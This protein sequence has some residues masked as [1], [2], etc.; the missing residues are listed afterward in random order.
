VTITVSEVREKL[1]GR[2][3]WLWHYLHAD[4]QWEQSRHWHEDRYA[5]AVQEALDLMQREPE[6]RYYFDTASEFFSAVAQRLGPRLEELKE[7]V[8]NGRIRLVSGQVANCR[9]TQVGDETYIRNLQLGREYFEKNLPPTDLSLFHSVDVA[10]GHVQMPQLLNLAGFKYYK[11]W[12]P[13][14][15]MNALGI[16]HQFIWQGID[17]SR[18]L[19]AR[20]TYGYGWRAN[21]PPGCYREDWEAAVVWLY[22]HLFHDQLLYDRSPT[23]HLWMIQGYDDARPLTD[24]VGDVPMDLLGFVAE[25]RRREKI[26]IRWCTPLEYCQAVAG[27]ADRLSVVEGVLD[28]ADCAYNMANSGSNGLWA[29][30]QMN[31]R[32]LLRAEW[33]AAAAASAGFV[34]PQEELK[35]LW[36]QHCIYQAHAQDFAFEED[37]QYLVDLAR[38]VKFHAE[39]IEQEAIHRIVHA[40]GGGDRATRYIFNPHPWP[41]EVEVE[42]YHPCAGAGVESLQVV[43]ED[44]NP[45]AQQQLAE[46]R[47]P[48]FGGSLNDERRLVRLKLPPMGYR[49]VQIVEK[50]DPA[51]PRPAPPSDGVVETEGLRLVYRNHAL[52]EVHDRATGHVYSSREGSPWPGLFFH[53]LDNQDWIFTGPEI[54][55]DRFVPESSV[56]LQ[57]GPLRWHHRSQGTLGPYRVQLDTSV[58]ERGRELQVQVCL[59]GHWELG[60]FASQKAKAPVTG[61]VTL[62]G[63]IEAG[64]RVTVDVPFAVEPRDPD[65]DIYVHN[66][67]RDRDLGNVDMFERLRPGVF[68]G[69]SWA[70]WSGDGHGVTLISVDG[71]YYWFKEPGQFGHILLRCIELKASTWE[72]FCPVFMT[73]TGTHYFHYAFRF[74]DGDWRLADPQRRSLEL[75]HPPVVARADYFAQAT[76]PSSWHSFLRLDGPALLS[77]YYTEGDNAYVRLYENMG[78]GGE[79]TLTLDWSPSSAQAVNLLGQ[80]LTVPVQASDRK[81]HV[82]LKPWQIVTLK[83]GR[84]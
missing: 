47:H 82:T 68:W 27:Q 9:P 29:W 70:D 28:G 61:F 32:R 83:L 19:V 72:A 64:G 36:Y 51:P 5:L 49:R 26:P 80:L 16:P 44:G 12:R 69:R 46:F 59:D 30:R 38:D 40:A 84:S 45:L 81:V 21:S 41:V 31:D 1:A 37:W 62:L 48:R 18:I 20:G 75:R 15:P 74:H 10:I 34:S 63:D 23:D 13:H 7:H 2:T 52:R 57:A 54:R 33:W 77:A 24:W 76:L 50:S 17:G 8:H 67:P 43:D 6:F 3:I 25:W 11:A 55:R 73:G 66:V 53:V 79:A 42:I 22:E 78:S 39:R 56:W 58:A 65:H 60:A 14:G 4:W 35:K 71:N